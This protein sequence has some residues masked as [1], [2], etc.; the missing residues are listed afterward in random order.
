MKEKPSGSKR[1]IAILMAVCAGMLFGTCFNPAQFVQD[2]YVR[3]L[4]EVD[5]QCPVGK[6]LKKHWVVFFGGFML[7]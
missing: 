7:G 4:N 5:A 2:R 1:M 3:Q 6:D